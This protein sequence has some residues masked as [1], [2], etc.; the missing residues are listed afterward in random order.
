MA[1][2][3]FNARIKYAA[4]TVRS[5]YGSYRLPRSRIRFVTRHYRCSR[6]LIINAL[7]RKSLKSRDARRN[8]TVE[9]RQIVWKIGF[10]PFKFSFALKLT[11]H[12]NCVPNAFNPT[13]GS[14]VASCPPLGCARNSQSKSNL[15][16][17]TCVQRYFTHRFCRQYCR[18]DKIWLM[19]VCVCVVL[20]FFLKQITFEFENVFF[21]PQQA[22]YV[23]DLK[24][25]ILKTNSAR[26]GCMYSIRHTRLCVF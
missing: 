25:I 12:M 2:I 20:I 8:T 19:C 26:K 23:L 4:Y 17:R 1:N 22:C 14:R 15:N 6:L 5:T 9:G 18:R 13:D 3:D 10:S 24:S 7:F 16:I 11:T 21:Y